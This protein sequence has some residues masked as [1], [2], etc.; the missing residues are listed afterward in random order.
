MHYWL[1]KTEP[2]SYSID[3]LQREKKT[4]WN[5]VRNYQARNYMRA[6]KKGDMV[7][8]YHSGE[9]RAIVGLAK[10]TTESY[11]DKTQ[12]DPKDS[13]YDPKATK[14]NPIWDLVDIA[15]VSKYKLPITLPHLKL[16]SF[17]D[18]MVLTQ[19]GSRL[20]VQPVAEKHFKKI[21]LMSK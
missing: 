7:F 14:S 19:R 15:F 3:D 17:F 20:S 11:P 9:E 6:M 12:F 4:A 8:F 21:V 18:S 2:E 1:M 13:H 10:V 16:D 5:G